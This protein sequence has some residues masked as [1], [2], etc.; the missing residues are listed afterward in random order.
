M[1]RIIIVMISALAGFIFSG[2]A[3]GAGKTIVKGAVR[4]G[5]HGAIEENID[6]EVGR[7]A[8]HGALNST[9]GVRDQNKAERKAEKAKEDP[10]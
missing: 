10:K 8:A 2:C 5:S 6:G 9:Y 7:G 4:G 1:N 3:N